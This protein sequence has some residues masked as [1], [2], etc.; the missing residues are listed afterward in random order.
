MDDPEQ[1]HIIN[2]VLQR[3]S[4]IRTRLSRVRGGELPLGSLDGVAGFGYTLVGRLNTSEC[5]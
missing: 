5:L 4:A 3:F 1:V 2:A